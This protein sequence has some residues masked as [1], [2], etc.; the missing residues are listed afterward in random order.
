M[1]AEP[2]TC[3]NCGAENAPERTTCRECG[4]PL[5][6]SGDEMGYNQLEQQNERGLEEAQ[7]EIRESRRGG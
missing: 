7:E 2:I 1:S 4:R 3:A 6:K 5:A